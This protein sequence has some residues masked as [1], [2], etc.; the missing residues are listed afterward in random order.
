[1][2]LILSYKDKH[3]TP[4]VVAYSQNKQEIE[5]KFDEVKENGYKVEV[6]EIGFRHKT[7]Y[8]SN[9]EVKKKVAKK[10]TK[11]KTS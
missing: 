5:D 10:Q 6:Y 7:Y 2:R 1:M 3:S 8:G 4:V 11:K 9:T